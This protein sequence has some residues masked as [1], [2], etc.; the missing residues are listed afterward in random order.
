MNLRR[1]IFVTV[2]GTALLAGCSQE[3]AQQT[4]ERP[5]VPVRVQVV[6]PFSD[7]VV[8][9]YTGSLEGE[10]QAVIYAKI[11][12]AVDSVLV[13]EGEDVK[14]GRILIKLDR[15]G[16]SSNYQ[17][18]QSVY[19]NADKHYNKMKYLFEEGAVSESA[20][21]AAKTDYE[22]ARASFESARRLVEIQS[23]IDGT[24]TSVKVRNGD[25]LAQ[26][27]EIATVAATDNLRVRFDVRTSDINLISV[28]DTVNVYSENL[29]HTGTG[30]VSAVAQSADPYKRSFR[31]EAVIPNNTGQF[32]PGMF[33]SVRI[34]LDRLENVIAVPREAVITTSAG[35]A[36]FTVFNG[37][38]VRRE[39]TLG[40]DL[41]G[42]VVVESGLE[43]GDTVV[44][45]GQSYLDKG[46]PVKIT[47]VEKG[48]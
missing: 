42:R 35:N 7:N 26:G 43:P 15:S 39:V 40:A 8:R 9:S 48:A 37:E 3:Q 30:I 17:Q 29:D 18:A 38:A 27:E 45:L 41:Q 10:K 44:T 19:R 25:F 16:P 5:A 11:A 21:D 24:V 12:E 32:R 13:R 20:F 14:A 34:I 4:T 22:V 6:T 46:T 2:V 1:H 31:V 36:I 47:G 28:G 23:P 33:V